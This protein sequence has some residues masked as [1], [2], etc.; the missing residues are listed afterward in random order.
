MTAYQPMH[1]T[2]IGLIACSRHGSWEVVFTHTAASQAAS[3]GVLLM[4][5]HD[6]ARSDIGWKGSTF[7]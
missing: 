7:A 5:F 4:Q 3:D 6:A 2:A 1:V